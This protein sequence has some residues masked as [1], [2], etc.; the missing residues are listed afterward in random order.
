MNMNMDIYTYIRIN[1][2]YSYTSIFAA[3]YTGA[4]GQAEDIRIEASQILRIRDSIVRQYSMLTGQSADAVARDLDRD[5][6]L[7]AEEAK[8]YGLIDEVVQPN[9]DK[10][11]AF[12][13]KGDGGGLG[14][15]DYE[16]GKIHVPKSRS[17]KR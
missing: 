6:F 15:E 17:A 13:V 9:A 1:N 5:N 14:G 10:I 2:F 4:Q 8:A 12:G 16:F 7:S 3:I 11:R